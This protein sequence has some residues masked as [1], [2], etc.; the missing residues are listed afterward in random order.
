MTEI[1]STLKA[2]PFEDIIANPLSAI[3]LGESQAARATADFIRE[4]GFDPPDKDNFDPDFGAIRMVYFKMQR[5]DS[6]GEPQTVTIQVPLLSLV[7]I[8]AIQVKEAV[9]D[10]SV[11]IHDTQTIKGQ[12]VSSGGNQ[13]LAKRKVKLFGAVSRR[14]RKAT[15]DT[16]TITETDMNVKVTLQQADFTIGV[17]R[18]FDLLEQNITETDNP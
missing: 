18:L 9:I 7:P 4:V 11:S 3:I 15:K 5:T 1:V 16:E 13:F 8:P 14:K 17:M 6:D 2:V 10:F 12:E